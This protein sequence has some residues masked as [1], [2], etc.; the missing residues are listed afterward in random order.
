MRVCILTE[1]H[2]MVLMGGAE[3]Q[4][5]LLAE[6]LSRREGVSVYYLA[7]RVPSEAAAESLSYAVR[8]IGNDGGIRRRAV[9]FDTPKLRRTLEELRPAVVYEQMKQSYTAVCAAYTVR[10]RIPFFLHMASEWD[11]DPTWFPF[12][13]SPNTPFDMVEAAAGNWG[14]RRATHLIVQTTAQGDKLRSRFNREPAILVRNFQPMAETLAPR[15]AGP[16]RVLW[17]GNIKE[18][19]RPELYVELVSLFADRSD[20]TFDMVGRPWLHHRAAP[21]MKRIAALP[22]L[23]FHGELPI[24]RVNEL[25]SAASFYVNT[26]AHEGFPNTFIQAWAHGAVLL[27]LVVDPVDG[28]DRLGIGFRTETL[29][30]MKTII[31]EL[32]SQP[33]RRL[34]IA[35]RSFD[36]ARENH[37][38]GEGAR[39]ADAMIDAARS[40]QHK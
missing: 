39:L 30:R 29:D 34:E 17:V 1:N 19:K 26:S 24:A 9:F 37:S 28:M 4:T 6:E 12:R 33:D 7:R 14:L 40:S 11:V 13:F 21:L 23:K 35:K 18:V 10:H 38:L 16:M 27:S 36:F 8:G 22:N 32:C 2:P 3:Y 15:P 31:S 25:M 20:V 5:H